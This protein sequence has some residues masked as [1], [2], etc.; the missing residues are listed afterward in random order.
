MA[1]KLY[2]VL[3]VTRQSITVANYLMMGL[4]KSV[5]GCFTALLYK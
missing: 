1:E 4:G 2:F 3:V 5:F